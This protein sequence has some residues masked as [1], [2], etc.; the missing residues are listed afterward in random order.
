MLKNFH[1]LTPK[2]LAHNH[3]LNPLCPKSVV[4]VLTMWKS[5]WFVACA[6][7]VEVTEDT[8]VI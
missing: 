3:P 8:H 2:I 4:Y 1:D 6:N 5:F 7:G